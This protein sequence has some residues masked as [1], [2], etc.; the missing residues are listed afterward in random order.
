MADDPADIDLDTSIPENVGAPAPRRG[1]PAGL[2]IVALVLVLAIVGA[3][4]YLRRPQPEAPSAG[5]KPSTPPVARQGLKGETIVLPPL[6]ETDPV[7]RELVRRLSSHPTVAAWLTTDGLVLNF[8]MV[9]AG[10]A[11]GES[12]TN[13]LKAIGP[14]PRI[15]IKETRDALY[16]DS[17]S[18]RRYDRYADA[19]ASLDARETARLYV[20][21]KPRIT[22][23][24]RR[25][26]NSGGDFDP[27][28]ER[29]IVELLRVP[30]LEGELELEPKGIVYGF[31]DPKLEQMTSAQKQ[32]LRMGPQNVRKI[33]EKLREIADYLAIPAARLR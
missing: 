26:G 32:L 33:Q 1:R 15:G 24:Y 11:N 5:A 25:L 6:D 20:T 31:A 30:V 19:F 4:V 8:V 22:D 23:A 3:Y 16:L 7:V 12:R 10:I 27:V 13:E 14:V 17:A 2:L 29:A 28:M 21:L 9:T 18:Y